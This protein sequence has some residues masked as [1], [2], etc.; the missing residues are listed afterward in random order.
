M[1]VSTWKEGKI[2]PE[3]QQAAIEAWAKRTGRRI[4]D[5]VED[6]DVSGR[7]FNRQIVECIE[8]VEAGEAR[9]IVVW[10]YSRFG[11]S[12]DGIAVNLKRLNDA[13]G[14]LESATE[15]ADARTATGRL[16]RGILFEFA[17]YESDA[18]GEQWRETHDHRR[19]RLHL[20]A[21]GRP[22]FGYEWHPRRIPDGKGGWT[23]QD[24]KYTAHPETG[25]VMADRYRQYI[26]GA[27]FYALLDDL[28]T[29]GWRTTRG[30]L[31]TAQTLIRYMDSGF[32]AALLRI[33]DPKCHCVS[34]ARGNCLNTLL[35]PGA[36]EELID[37]E[38]W[39]QYQDRRQETKKTPPRSRTALYPLT[40]LVRCAGCR[41]TTPVQSATRV[42]D[43]RPQSTKGHNY[44]CG[45]RAVTGT[46]GCEGVYA[47]RAGVE[48][49]VHKWLMD[50]ARA[51]DAPPSVPPPRDPAVDQRETA[52]RERARLE[53]E[54]AKQKKALA[55]LRVDR[56]MNP[57]DYG[58]GEYEDAVA[59]I[60]QQ[61]AATTAAL[62]WVSVVGPRPR[63]ADYE[64]VI[65]GL[66]EKWELLNEG[67]KNG[68]LKQLVRR[69]ALV[70]QEKGF[71][72][73]VHPMWEPDPWA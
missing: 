27:P 16:Q 60:R 10:K 67:E 3:L 36:Q 24:E 14:E 52:A 66:V 68:M 59:R 55:N 30:G 51:I 71:R 2:S 49:E 8:R 13:G 47:V 15:E 54:A 46:H 7:H 38:L 23:L 31:W 32:C 20:P 34:S 45:R 57:D 35:I 69:V 44:M 29:A 62:E 39:Q 18:C 17:A 28:N 58:P 1:R 43:G 50:Q 4:V 73:E 48:K 9:G 63:Q 61:Q 19:Y 72:V 12:R 33:H 42:V 53:G 21:T 22:R 37:L 26:D 65:V 25:P 6:L 41:G 40:G 70:R 56:A 11:R 5:F 64:P